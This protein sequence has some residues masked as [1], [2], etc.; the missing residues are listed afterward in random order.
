MVHTQP[1]R[2]PPGLII[3]AGVPTAAVNF[4]QCYDIRSKI[5]QFPGALS[6]VKD[7]GQV[8]PVL[9]IV[10]YYLDIMQ[11]SSPAF[12]IMS[13]NSLWAG[14]IPLVFGEPARR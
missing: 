1:F 2:Q 9:D 6:Q 13:L 10:G 3:Q 11:N 5:G 12:Q 7:S 14:H 8:A 4:L